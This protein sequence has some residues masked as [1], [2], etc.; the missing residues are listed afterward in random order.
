MHNTVVYLLT[1]GQEVKFHEI[2]INFSGGR[3]HEIEFFFIF[4]EVKIPNNQFDLL[5]AAVFMMSKLPN[6]TF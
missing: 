4:H 1:Q 6:Y 3:N 2:E 5:I